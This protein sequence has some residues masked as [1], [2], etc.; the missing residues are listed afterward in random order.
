MSAAAKRRETLPAAVDVVDE[1]GVEG[2]GPGGDE[3]VAGGGGGGVP[4]E[5]AEGLVAC[6]EET[7]EGVEGDAVGGS[8]GGGA[9]A[10]GPCVVGGP[11]DV[12]VSG[13]DGIEDG[14]VGL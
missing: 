1:G 12:E 11:D 5:G 2:K 8:A 3:I 4:C 14:V 7:R 6:G 10:F 13:V 9:G